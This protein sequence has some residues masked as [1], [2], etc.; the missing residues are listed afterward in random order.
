MY[1]DAG[2]DRIEERVVADFDAMVEAV[3]TGYVIARDRK[4]ANRWRGR[5]RPG[6]KTALTGAA[7]ESAI[8]SLAATH[9]EYVVTH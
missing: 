4:A 1:L 8:M 5:R 2:I 3:R 7:L 6:R 9:P